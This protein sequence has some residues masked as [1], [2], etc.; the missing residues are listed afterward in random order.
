MKNYRNFTFTVAILMIILNLSLSVMALDPNGMDPKA[1]TNPLNP[2]KIWKTLPKEY[3]ED[4]RIFQGISSLEITSN[5]QIWVT[6]YAGGETENAE[7]YVLLAT[8]GD[9]GNT[10]SKPILA[11][12]PP[13]IVRA[14]DPAIWMDPTGKLWFFWSQ[15]EESKFNPSIWDGRVGVWTI[16]TENPEDGSK[17]VWSQPRRLCD[18]IMMGKPIVDSKGRYLFPVSIWRYNSKYNIPMERRGANVYVSTD[19]GKTFSYL[20]GSKVPL[21]DS[22]F[23][24]HCLLEKKDG[25]L[26]IL[27]RTLYGI[28][29]SFS[30]DN[31]KTWTEM[32]PS[33]TLKHT[34]SRFFVRRLASGNI[35]LV[36]NGKPDENIGR[37]KMMAFISKD[38]GKTFKGGLMLDER[39]NVSYPDGNQTPDGTIFVTY[40]YDRYGAKEIY[41]ARFTEEDILAGKIVSEKSRLRLLVSKATG[42]KPFVEIKVDYNANKDGKP[43]MSGSLAE[44]DFGKLKVDKIV[45]D[46]KIFTDREYTFHDFPKELAGKRFV[47]GSIMGSQGVCTKE[48]IV[49]VFTPQLNRNK[50]SIVKD[51]EAAGFEKVALPE[52]LLFGNIPGNVVTLYQ[53]KLKTGEKIKLGKW[54][55][56]VF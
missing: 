11:I 26:W 43:L 31:G 47:R 5:N 15:G 44:L 35:L 45:K 29:E 52:V 8:S 6:W 46:I 12:D 9:R 53:K 24:E 33:K 2:P 17:A 54:G 14:F 7:N 13:G 16:T 4:A 41:A 38:D 34:C 1:P 21:K 39:N 3:L 22:I 36:K 32:A 56:I 19:Q 10:W 48:G 20:G 42:T 25:S 23:D 40:D 55:V 37:K 50:D 51:L 27:A 49:Y 18:G 28:G 30:T